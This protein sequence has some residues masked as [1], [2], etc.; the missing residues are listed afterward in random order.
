MT[1]PAADSRGR[2]ALE[3]KTLANGNRPH[4]GVS[5]QRTANRRILSRCS[6]NKP[7]PEVDFFV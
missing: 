6:N 5:R 3:R 4:P 7:R 1:A 2:G